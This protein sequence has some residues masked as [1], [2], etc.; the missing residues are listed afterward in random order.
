MRINEHYA[1][2]P[3]SYLFPEIGRR[4][5]AYQAAHTD[6]AGSGA[7]VIRLG[8]G[9]VTEPLA[10]AIVAAMHAAVDE[11]G[12]RETFHGYGPEQGYDFLV[13]AIRANDYAARGV[14]IAADE[15][16]VSDGSKC[17]SGNVQEIFAADARIAIAD[18]VYPV[19]V[20]SNVMAGRTAAAGPDGRYPGFVYL[21]GTEA[22]NFQPD[23]PAAANI[24]VAYLCSPNNPT[25]TVATRAQLE[26]WVDRKSVV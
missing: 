26:R 4:V 11:M 1:K 20:D 19:Y 25:G 9:D 7:N 12:R 15:I 8:I 10:P 22:N 24:D 16:F 3:A 5:R 6:A 23:P 14:D 2:L 17:D 13:E 21:Q 18:P